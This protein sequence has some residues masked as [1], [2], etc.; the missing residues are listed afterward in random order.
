MDVYIKEDIINELKRGSYESILNNV[1]SF[2]QES[3]NKIAG[4]SYNGDINLLA[5]FKRHAIV[6]DNASNIYRV[7]YDI[8]ANQ[9]VLKSS[10][11]I[12]SI[13]KNTSE[14]I[15]KILKKKVCE[16]LA[17]AMGQDSNN[18]KLKDNISDLIKYKKT[19][20]VNGYTVIANNGD[21]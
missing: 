13:K 4:E 7:E 20:Q 8:E 14:Q 19:G 9:L 18:E 10:S 11:L 21:K 6:A 16:S 1:N 3:K 15:E 2:L 12:E 5:S 17:E